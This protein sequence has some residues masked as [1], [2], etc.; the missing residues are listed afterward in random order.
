MSILSGNFSILKRKQYKMKLWK[1]SKV[2]GFQ[3]QL[4]LVPD[5]IICNVVCRENLV[6][7]GLNIF[8]G[9]ITPF[10][11]LNYYDCV[12]L[13]LSIGLSCTMWAHSHF[14]LVQLLRLQCKKRFTQSSM[15]SK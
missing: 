2:D 10:D 9:R 3:L 6:C 12:N 1:K 15:Q 5:Q 11:L 4:I 7:L 13:S 14:L 8:K